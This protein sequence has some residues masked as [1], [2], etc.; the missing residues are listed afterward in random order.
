MASLYVR[1]QAGWTPIGLLAV[2]GPSRN[3]HFGLPR[4]LA[5]TLSKMPRSSQKRR[6]ARSR[7]GKSTW[8]STFSNNGMTGPLAGGGTGPFYKGGR[9]PAQA[10]GNR[11]VSAIADR[12]SPQRL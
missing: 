8:V 2:I 9:P 4:F 1:P 3:D 11:D 5:R 12:R 6:T 10:R 7:A